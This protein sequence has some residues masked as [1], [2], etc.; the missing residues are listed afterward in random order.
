MNRRSNSSHDH[1]AE[2]LTRRFS[3][4]KEERCP[5][6]NSVRLVEK[7]HNGATTRVRTECDVSTE[8]PVTVGLH[9]GSALSPLLVVLLLDVLS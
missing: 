8:F 2:P 6:T 1:K 5:R 9:Q 7:M 3:S 4:P